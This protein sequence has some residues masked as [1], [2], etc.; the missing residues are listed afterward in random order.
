MNKKTDR[1]AKPVGS[2]RSLRDF[3]ELLTSM[4]QFVT[5]PHAVMP[6]PDIQKVAVAAGRD[7]MNGPAILFDKILGYPGKRVVAYTGV[8]RISPQ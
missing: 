2:V 1:P 5:W 6:E 4:G 8:S 3:L 7:T